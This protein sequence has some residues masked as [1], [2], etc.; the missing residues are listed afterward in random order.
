V[1]QAGKLP[2]AK[3]WWV[4]IIQTVKGTYYTGI[5]VDLLRRYREHCSSPTKRAKYFALSPVKSIT[6][7]ETCPNRSTAL[8]RECAI[9]RLSRAQKISLMAH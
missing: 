9:K 6:Y 7:I 3:I 4:Y 8:K 5:T 1:K 2:A